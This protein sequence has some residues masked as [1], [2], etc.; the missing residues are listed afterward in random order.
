MQVKIARWK[1]VIGGIGLKLVN[2]A[3][4]TE[5]GRR[6]LSMSALT[7]GSPRIIRRLEQYFKDNS[8]AGG[9]FNH[10]LPAAYFLEHQATLLPEMDD[11]TLDRAEKLFARVNGLLS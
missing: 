9:T 6:K 11:A 2:G 7:K 3:Y 1:Q 10:Y 8:I 4:R 5:L